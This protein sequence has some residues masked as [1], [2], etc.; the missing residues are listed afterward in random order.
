MA[1]VKI[2]G[3][4]VLFIPGLNRIMKEWADAGFTLKISPGFI[5]HIASGE[6]LSSASTSLLA[7]ALLLIA[8][9]EH[10]ASQDYWAYCNQ[11][12]KNRPVAAINCSVIRRCT[13]IQITSIYGVNRGHS[14]LSQ[15]I[16]PIIFTF[17]RCNMRPLT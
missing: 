17:K 3:T 12:R 1:I 8:Y 14:L 6:S 9:W 11:P 5:A 4:V 7:L 10:H 13:I 15:S 2:L 16:S